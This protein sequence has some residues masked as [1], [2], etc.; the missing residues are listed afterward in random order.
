MNQYPYYPTNRIQ[1]ISSYNASEVQCYYV[2]S[3][4]DLDK[5]QVSYGTL[6]IGINNDKKEIYIKQMNNN[7]LID[8]NTYAMQSGEQQKN[9]YTVI[10]EKLD[11][12]TKGVGNVQH[13]SPNG[14]I[15]NE[16]VVTGQITE[17]S[18]NATV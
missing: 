8:L 12:L 17:S 15:T 13:Q 3:P 18:P 5:I 16:P 6:Y 10:L 2:S 1:N 11:E 4:K 9:E 7:G 14:A